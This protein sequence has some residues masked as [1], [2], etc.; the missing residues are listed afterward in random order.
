MKFAQQTFLSLG[1]S[2]V[3]ADDSWQ[4]LGLAF[5]DF[6]FVECA[7]VLCCYFFHSC[8]IGN[9]GNRERGDETHLMGPVG[10]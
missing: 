10:K 8:R 2:S 4:T 5:M 3:M 9:Y 1:R 7:H 6:D